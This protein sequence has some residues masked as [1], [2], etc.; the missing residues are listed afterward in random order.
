MENPSDRAVVL[1]SLARSPRHP[2]RGLITA[3]QQQSKPAPAHPHAGPITPRHTRST[4]ARGRRGAGRTCSCRRP[5]CFLERPVSH[6]YPQGQLGPGAKEAAHLLHRPQLFGGYGT[7]GE[8]YTQ[9]PWPEGTPQQG[10]Q[11]L[12]AVPRVPRPSGYQRGLRR[13]RQ[14]FRRAVA[15]QQDEV[16]RSGRARSSSSRC[17]RSFSSTCCS[18]TDPGLLRDPCTRQRDKA[19]GSWRLPRGRCIHYVRREAQ[20]PYRAAGVIADITRKSRR[21]TSTATRSTYARRPS[22]SSHGDK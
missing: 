12:D 21:S 10:Y 17:A 16:R 7:M 11:S 3:K 5:R 4:C 13:P 18:T 8:E 1:K 14:G 2:R 15:R 6:P 19:A 9:G 20:R 22:G